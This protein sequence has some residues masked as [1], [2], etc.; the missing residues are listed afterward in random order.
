MTTQAFY[1]ES[2]NSPPRRIPG[3]N[4]GGF[5]LAFTAWAVPLMAETDSY[6]EIVLGFRYS[7]KGVTYVGVSGRNIPA[8]GT[9]LFQLGTESGGAA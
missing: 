9:A 4:S 2:G 3:G 1:T 6:C 5:K 8:E 7:A